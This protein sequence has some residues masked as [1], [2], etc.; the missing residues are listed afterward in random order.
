MAAARHVAR[1]HER[2]VQAVARDEVRL[3]RRGRGSQANGSVRIVRPKLV[4]MDLH[5]L[6]KAWLLERDVHPAE[7][8][9]V[10]QDCVIVRKSDAAHD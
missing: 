6:L 7:V 10:D 4:D 8:E 9:V 5:P 1:L 3:P 2:T